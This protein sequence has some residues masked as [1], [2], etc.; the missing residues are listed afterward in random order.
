MTHYGGKRDFDANIGRRVREIREGAGLT[1]AQLGAKASMDAITINLIE[2][3]K[4]YVSAHELWDLCKAL[5][6]KPGEFLDD[7]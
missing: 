6:A 1:Q 7:V 2:N 4:R 3:D 5:N